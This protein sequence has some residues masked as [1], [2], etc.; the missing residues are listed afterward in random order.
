MSNMPDGSSD[1]AE[2]L[3]ALSDGELEYSAI[4]GLCAEWRD[5]P[6]TRARWH[7]YQLIG[8]VLRSD[9]LASPGSRDQEFLSRLRERLAAEP[10]VLAPQ[11]LPAAAEPA[12]MPA[13]HVRRSWRHWRASAAMAAGFLVVAVGASNLLLR[14]QPAVETATGPASTQGVVAATA[15]RD[16]SA[17]EPAPLVA[18]G[19]LIRDARID[20]YLAAHQQLSGGSLLGGH[21]AFLRQA[22]T[23]VPK[24]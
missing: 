6:A 24:R 9:D 20:H 10:V 8:D 18:N 14:E 19:T 13:G 3:S 7:S 12:A 15:A 5:D 1:R 4:A 11:A 21:A 2:Q 23:D 22:A 17:A 16:A